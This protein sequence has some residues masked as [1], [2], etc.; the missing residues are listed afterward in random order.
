[1]GLSFINKK[2][3]EEGENDEN[4]ATRAGYFSVLLCE[5]SLTQNRLM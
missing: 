4:G 1:M 5:Q 3:A 2:K